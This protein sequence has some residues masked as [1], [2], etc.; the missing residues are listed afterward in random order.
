MG[1]ASRTVQRPGVRIETIVDSGGVDGAGPALVILPSYGRDGGEDYDE[2]TARL[3]R[4]GWLVLRPQ[5]RGVAGSAGPMTGLTLHDLADDV[6]AV[7]RALGGGSAVLLGHAFGNALSRMIA[8]DHPGLVR[9][10]I[11]AASQASEVPPD[12][13][14]APFIAGDL[15]RPEEERLAVL[16]RCFFAPGHDAAPWLKGWYPETLKMQREAAHAVPVSAYWNCGQAPMLEIFGAFDPF[17]PKAF[18]S[19]L[20]GQFGSRIASVMIGDASHALFP[21]QPGKVAETIV[22]WLAARRDEGERTMSRR[23][24]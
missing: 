20:S 9:G 7:I 11:L 19:E 24:G 3:V 12:I 14:G 15:S 18:W 22:S 4:A 17:K 2:I 6:A 10:V 5:P 8:S 13:A 16:R 21:E 1:R 23:V